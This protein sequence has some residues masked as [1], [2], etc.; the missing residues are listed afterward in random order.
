MPREK[1]TCKPSTLEKTTWLLR[2]FR[3]KDCL[4]WMFLTKFQVATKKDAHRQDVILRGV[5]SD[6]R[7]VK[8]A[9]ILKTQ[10]KSLEKSCMTTQEQ[11]VP[12]QR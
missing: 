1:E 4:P 12:S 5:H 8:M 7:V 10:N 11:K 3:S 2:N 6:A 9:R